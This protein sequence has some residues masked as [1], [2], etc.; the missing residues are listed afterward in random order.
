MAE[1]KRMAN[2]QNAVAY[3]VRRDLIS[4][5]TQSRLP[6]P[7]NCVSTFIDVDFGIDATNA[8]EVAGGKVGVLGGERRTRT[9]QPGVAAI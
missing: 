1:R 2:G 7:N 9:T 3:H 6:Q 5:N 4:S 8:L